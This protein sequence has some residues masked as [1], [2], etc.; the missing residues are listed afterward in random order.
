MA[1]FW[2][3]PPPAS[4]LDLVDGVGGRNGAPDPNAVYA[5]HK[6][7]THGFSWKM[8]VRD[9]S[10]RKWD[11]KFNPEAQPEVVASRIVWALGYHQAPDYYLPV[12]TLERDGTRRAMPPARFRP[13]DGWI[14]KEGI[15]Q[16][17]ANPFVNTEPFRGLVVLMMV[18]NNT[19]LKDDNNALYELQEASEHASRWYV[20]KDLGATLGNAAALHAVRNDLPAFEHEP[21]ISGVRDGRVLFDFRG[22]HQDLLSVVHP[23]DVA[24]LCNR[25]DAFSAADW[26]QMFR[27]GGY[28]EEES[29]RFIAKIREKIAQGKALGGGAR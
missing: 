9:P 15:W 24:W 8:E 22:R 12:W 7:K 11:V 29:A 17:H 4:S 6:Q 23:E 2:N 13:H 26:A 27:A 20:V 21:F 10:G 19:D 1:E 5:F 18:L 14:S 3:P 25:L 16:W 28:S